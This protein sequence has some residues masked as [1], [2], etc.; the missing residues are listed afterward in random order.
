MFGYARRT[1]SDVDARTQTMATDPKATAQPRPWQRLNWEWEG[2]ATIAREY[3]AD[4]SSVVDI[5]CGKMTLKRLLPYG[6]RYQG[7]D[8]APRD[9]TTIVLDLNKERLPAMDFDA[10]NVLGVMEYIDDPDA[11]F[12]QLEQFELL[13]FSYNCKGIKDVLTNLGI[14]RSTPKGWR[15]RLTKAEIIAL[16]ER[17]GFKIFAERKVR[18]SEYLWA[19]RRDPVARG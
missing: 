5:G 2:R 16:I 11:F 4:V 17:H 9:E 10:A 14:L 19:A 6:V 15:N 18:T 13:V 3:L 1:Q 7:V 8:I 12:D